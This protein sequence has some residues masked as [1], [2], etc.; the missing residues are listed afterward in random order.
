MLPV[1][2]MMT[3]IVS[4]S[5]RRD[6]RLSLKTL[7]GIAAV[8]ALTLSAFGQQLTDDQ[9]RLAIAR[10]NRKPHQI[11]LTLNDKQT[12]F[13][14]RIVC[15]T[16]GQSGYTITV[17]NPEQWV[18]LCAAQAKKE[19]QPFSEAD[20]T[21]EMRAQELHVVALPSQAE[22]LTGNGIAGSSSVHRVVLND[23]AR[24]TTIQPLE[25]RQNT[26]QGNSAF[27]SIEY[28]M[29][30]A[31]F[32]LSDV[33]R[34]R[35]SD[36]KGE[37]F[38]VVVGDNQNKF[39][40]VKSRDFKTLFPKG[41]DRRTS[42]SDR[43]TPVLAAAVM[44]VTPPPSERVRPETATAVQSTTAA[45]SAAAQVPAVAAKIETVPAAQSRSTTTVAGATATAEIR[46]DPNPFPGSDPPPPVDDTAISA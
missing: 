21:D 8:L 30:S 15:Q 1:I 11:G 31:E 20:V 14:S 18:E 41:G 34:L 27:R 5:N 10:G 28:T 35:D 32:Y 46:Q 17:Y 45:A 33:A 4:E 6:Q 40:K 24:Q 22:Y 43:P 16:C 7:I 38:I 36:P 9:V 42:A 12:A 3:A 25:V 44:P 23:T 2:V 39:F 19:M 26:L 13:F 37:F 29:A